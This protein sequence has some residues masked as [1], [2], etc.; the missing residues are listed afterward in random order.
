[1][2]PL[3]LIEFVVLSIAPLC[4]THSFRFKREQGGWLFVPG[5][6]GDGGAGIGI[7]WVGMS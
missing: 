7:Q 5:G 1:M 6:Y 4:F 2:P 3:K